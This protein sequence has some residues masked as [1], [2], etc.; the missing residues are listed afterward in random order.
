MDLHFRV[1]YLFS[2]WHMLGEFDFC[3]VPFADGLDETIF[4]DVRLIG[5]VSWHRRVQ[6]VGVDVIVG[7]LHGTLKEQNIINILAKDAHIN[8]IRLNNSLP[9]QRARSNNNLHVYPQGQT[10]ELSEEELWLWPTF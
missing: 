7:A 3:K 10:R 6:N 9:Q 8:H 5:A 4:S 2:S 1:F